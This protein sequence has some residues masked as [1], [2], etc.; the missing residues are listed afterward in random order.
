MKKVTLDQRVQIVKNLATFYHLREQRVTSKRINHNKNTF[1]STSKPS[2]PIEN[3][4]HKSNTFNIFLH[5]LLNQYII[6]FNM[7]N[8][9]L[10][11]KFSR[12]DSL[13]RY[14]ENMH[15]AKMTFI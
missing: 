11:Y 10:I 8:P 14:F 9:R 13:K 15:I 6:Y 5:Y 12:I 3:V 2:F 1:N 7:L 4:K